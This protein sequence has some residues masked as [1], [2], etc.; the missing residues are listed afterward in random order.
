MLLV[1]AIGLVNT[2]VVNAIG[3]LVNAMMVHNNGFTI[4]LHN[5]ECK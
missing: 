4:E 5:S 1:N 2:M 3:L